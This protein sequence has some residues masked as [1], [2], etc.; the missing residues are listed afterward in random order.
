LAGN[1]RTAGIQ[2][3]APAPKPARPMKS[4]TGLSATA[5]ES[6]RLFQEGNAIPKIAALRGFT[7]GTIGGHL[8]QAMSLGL[9]DISPREFYTEEEETRIAAAVA[10]H[11]VEQVGTLFHALGG[12]IA[13]AKLN[14]YRAFAKRAGGNP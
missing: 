7:E 12:D 3:E 4:E 6:L 1:A 5:L 13:Y 2:E 10:Q 9:L 14:F 8:A 11:G